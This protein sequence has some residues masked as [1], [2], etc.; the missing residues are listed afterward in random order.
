MMTKPIVSAVAPVVTGHNRNGAKLVAESAKNFGDDSF[1]RKNRNSW[2]I[3][4]RA[5]LLACSIHT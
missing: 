3:P 4:L 5:T 2:R 1:L